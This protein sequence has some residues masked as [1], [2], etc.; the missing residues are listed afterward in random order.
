MHGVPPSHTALHWVLCSALPSIVTLHNNCCIVLLPWQGV[1]A[2]IS[3]RNSTH[4]CQ[5]ILQPSLKY[6]YVQ[7]TLQQVTS[8]HGPSET[9]LHA[10]QSQKTWS[11]NRK[12][13]MPG[14]DRR[15]I[16]CWFKTARLD[17]FT[18]CH[19]CQLIRSGPQRTSVNGPHVSLIREQPMHKLVRIKQQTPAQSGVLTGASLSALPTTATHGTVPHVPS[20]SVNKH[21]STQNTVASP[22]PVPR[23][24]AR[25]RPVRRVAA[26]AAGRTTLLPAHPK[27]LCFLSFRCR[28]SIL[29]F[30]AS[31][32]FMSPAASSRMSSR[33]VQSVGSRSASGASTKP[34][35]AQSHSAQSS[36]TRPLLSVS[37]RCDSQLPRKVATACAGATSPS[38]ASCVERSHVDTDDIDG[39]NDPDEPRSAESVLVAAGSGEEFPPPL[40]LWVRGMR[41]SV[42]AIVLPR[43][44]LHDFTHKVTP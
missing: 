36:S 6:P 28:S 39:S 19:R 29:C 37:S 27:A 7:G 44:I 16:H 33:N 4:I 12:Y 34:H 15:V 1:C 26:T 3:R 24:A 22:R 11:S 43:R 31:A 8:Y 5:A 10:T 30:A 38:A 13:R 32:P 41:R 2:F 14:P 9:M 23:Q 18:P 25:R 21:G 17:P 35:G 20:G 40:C 42:G